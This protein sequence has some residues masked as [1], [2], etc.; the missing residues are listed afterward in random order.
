MAS[1]QN[2][3]AGLSQ[4]RGPLAA[5]SCLTLCNPMDRSLL[6]S[7]VQGI[8]QGRMLEW[9]AISFSG[10]TFLTQGS[11]LCLLHW[12]ADSLPLS[13]VGSLYLRIIS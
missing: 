3:T 7:S 12:Q 11:N 10:G 1:S 2:N 4:S 6:G 13:H 9:V 5:K 8:F